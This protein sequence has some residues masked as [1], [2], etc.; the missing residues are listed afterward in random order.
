MNNRAI[1][2]Q[3]YIF[4]IRLLVYLGVHQKAMISTIHSSTNDNAS[5]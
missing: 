5:Q 1:N 3:L 4:G 2:K